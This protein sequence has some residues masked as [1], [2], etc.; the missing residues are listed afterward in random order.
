MLKF[1]AVA[2]ELDIDDGDGLIQRSGTDESVMTVLVQKFVADVIKGA[3][4]KVV[5]EGIVTAD[6]VNNGVF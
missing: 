5:V 1:D 4:A 3:K 6:K 2:K